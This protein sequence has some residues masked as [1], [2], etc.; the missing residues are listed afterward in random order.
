M[1][2]K[3]S[4]ISILA[5]SVTSLSA[6]QFQAIGYQAISMG[7]AGVANSSGSVST[8]NNPALL[9]K[10]KYDVEISLGGGISTQDH[11][12]GASMQSLEDT[13]FMDTIDKASED[14]TNL[15][16]S[17]VDN[18]YAGKDI[19]LD[20]D[21]KS[22]EAAPHGYMAAQ[23]S[24]F[25]LGVF[26][27]SD[28]VATANV[29]QAHDR[30]IFQDTASLG[31]Y[32]E[33]DSAG[34]IAA[35]DLATYQASSM[36]YA[37]NNGLTNAQIQAIVISEVPVAY[38][39]KFEL[40]GGNIYVGGAM[41][42][43]QATAYTETMKIDN[44]EESGTSD[45][46]EYSSSNF[47]LDLGLAY[48]PSFSKDLMLALVAKNLNTL[49]FKLSDSVDVEIEPMIRAGVA[50]NIFDSLEVAVDMDLTKNKT[51]STTS[52]SQMLG[53]GLA[54]SPSSW[55]SL[56][57]GLM[58][59]MDTN[60]EAGMIYTAGVGFGLKWFQ[61][62]LSGQMSEKTETVNGTDFPQYTKVNLALVSRW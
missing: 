54:Y 15:T 60:D 26:G 20:I 24:G 58:Q 28:A 16:Q 33:L 13:H 57:G 4:L 46:E 52:D 25:G 38:G 8:Y 45:K 21:G 40:S 37:V 62:D 43:M 29:S 56:R 17:D 44:S 41:K 19:I 22:V 47:G 9:A 23:V 59:N 11:G 48:E 12:A 32:V 27:T 39:H 50:Y 5:L 10:S 7:G 36:E 31:L 53:G 6:M 61:I 18:L 14:V 3:L 42:Y 2:I 55:F 35:S 1:K 34:N 30:F 51:F 49:S